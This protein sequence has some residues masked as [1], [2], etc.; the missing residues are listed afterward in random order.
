MPSSPLA[1]W[2]EDNWRED[3]LRREL[4]V[5]AT[6]LAQ[7]ANKL[8]YSEEFPT[9]TPPLLC[10]LFKETAQIIAKYLPDIPQDHLQIVNTVLCRLA[11]FLRYA[12]RSKVTQTPWSMVQATEAFFKLQGGLKCQFAIRPQWAFNY[13]I[14]GE[15]VEVCRT[16][17]K[18]L[19]WIPLAEWEQGV[20]KLTDM[21]IYCVS[22]PRTH[23]LNPLS[24]AN[25]G[26]E[27][28][29]IVA[30]RWLAK[31]FQAI[32][33]E[34]EPGIKTEIEKDVLANPPPVIDLWKDVAIKETIAAKITLTMEVTRQGIEELLCDAIGVHLMG[35]AALASACEF[36][37]RYDLDESPVMRGGHYPPWRYRLR[38]MAEA[39]Q[40]DL[41]EH[42]P[43]AGSTKGYPGNMVT[44]YFKWLTQILNLV[45]KNADQE[46]LKKGVVTREAYKAI[47]KRWP[48]IKSEVIAQLPQL[49][50]R[51]YRLHE[52]IDIIE[53]LVRKLSADLPPNEVGDWPSVSPASLEDILNAG[54]AFKLIRARTDAGWATTEN[55][56]KLFRL[57]LKGIESS[58][59]ARTF[60]PRVTKVGT[61]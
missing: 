21:E 60:G 31:K 19:P 39:C 35:P 51:P 15:F 42:P 54:W 18:L 55:Y 45:A 46:V 53:E 26:H 57:I 40:E 12:E 50:S 47:E 29:H 23:R 56:E 36:C 9:D 3:I 25:W 13:G 7:L 61:S 14:V 4:S 43:K 58:F 32:W 38:L 1:P 37:A 44:P 8:G 27:I 33:S 10:R 22:F 5:Q 24:H 30:G 41:Q 49:S 11:E 59:V 48:V 52:R 6:V 2:S 34:E 20:G 28:G 16:N 17:I